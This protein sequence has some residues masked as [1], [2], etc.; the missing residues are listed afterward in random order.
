MAQKNGY[1]QLD[2]KEGSVRLKYFPPVDGGEPLKMDEVIE[3]LAD[4]HIENYNMKLINETILTAKER[5][6]ISSSLI[7][8]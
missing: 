6:W 5:S 2:I 3:Y 1:F 4:R 8:V 7:P